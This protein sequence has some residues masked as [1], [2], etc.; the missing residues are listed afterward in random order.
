[1]YWKVKSVEPQKDFL[2]LLSFEDGER[3]IF[4]MKPYLHI[5]VFQALQNPEI[6]NSVKVCASSIAWINNADI[7]PELLYTKGTKI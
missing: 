3:R 4:D 1:M 6:F 5:G 2:L 7:D